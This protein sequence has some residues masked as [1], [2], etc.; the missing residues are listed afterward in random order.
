MGRRRKGVRTLYAAAAWNFRK[1]SDAAD[2]VA[3]RQA[4]VQAVL[5]LHIH[6]AGEPQ[7]PFQNAAVGD[8][9]ALRQPGR[10]RR[11]EDHGWCIGGGVDLIAACDI[12]LAS[13]DAQF[14]VRETKIAIVAD[15]G[16]LQRLPAA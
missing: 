10:T 15:V 5:R 4:I 1:R 7:A 8:L 9:G 3:E 2:A 13:A 12:R 16:S 14:S 6:H 11:V